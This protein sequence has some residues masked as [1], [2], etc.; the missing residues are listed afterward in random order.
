MGAVA[1]GGVVVLDEATIESV[2]PDVVQRAIDDETQEIERR[3]CVYRGGGP[4]ASLRGRVVILV[5][6]GLATGATMLAAVQAVAELQPEH[7]VV[8]VPVCAAPSCAALENDADEVVCLEKPEPFHAVGLWYADFSQTSDDE[9]RS[10]LADA[11]SRHGPARS[12]A[13]S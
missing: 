5:D 2:A 8:A 3:E 4:A 10:L 9:V 11:A 13:M 1:S 6:D 12:A 7:V